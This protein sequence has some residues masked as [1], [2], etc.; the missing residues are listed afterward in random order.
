MQ[1]YF[2]TGL[3]HNVFASQSRAHGIGLFTRK[4]LKVKDIICLYS[5]K[6]VSENT[7]GKYIVE[8]STTEGKMFIDGQDINNFSGRWINHSIRPNARLVQ[9]VGGILQYNGRSVIFVECMKPIYSGQ[10]IFI[11]YGLK[12]FMKGG[13]L[14]KTYDYGYE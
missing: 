2:R 3:E 5:G 8:V 14:D 13:V 6:V 7:E 12:Y 11:N 9:P 4:N 10:E 1:P